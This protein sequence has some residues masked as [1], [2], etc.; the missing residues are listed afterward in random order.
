[1]KPSPVV[2]ISGVNPGIGDTAKT[3]W[4]RSVKSVKYA[5]SDDDSA[6]EAAVKRSKTTY[7]ASGRKGKQ[8]TVKEA[9]NGD[10]D[11]KGTSDGSLSPADTETED[12]D[13]ARYN[14]S[15]LPRGQSARKRN[16]GRINTTGS[17]P[18]P[19]AKKKGEDLDG[20]ESSP[21][22][23]QDDEPAKSS[24]RKAPSK[25]DDAKLPAKRRQ[26]ASNGDQK[27]KKLASTTSPKK[28]TASARR[29]K[30]ALEPQSST[31]LTDPFYAMFG[32]SQLTTSR[33]MT[34][35]ESSD[36][37][38]RQKVSRLFAGTSLTPQKRKGQGKDG[39]DGGGKRQKGKGRDES[40]GDTGASS[41][42]EAEPAAIDFRRD[43]T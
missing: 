15:D 39:Q 31:Q 11:E 20:K 18:K 29:G 25:R 6:A 22:N 13:A 9:V 36:E 2:L 7:K 26:P 8:V 12:A 21:L 10:A 19:A 41:S 16:Q 40:G 1:M 37:D 24:R 14:E 30:P 5:E 35:S 32:S 42:T 28:A 4:G 27:Y 17:K 33:I 43:L 38:E 3:R 23:A 34:D